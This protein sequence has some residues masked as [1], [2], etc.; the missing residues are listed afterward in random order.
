M[1]LLV[2]VLAS[3]RPSP[4]P[5]AVDRDAVYWIEDDGGLGRRL[6]SVAKTGGSIRTLGDVGGA[7]LIA[8]G[9]RLFFI[10]A[11]GVK[12]LRPGGIPHP[13]ASGEGG[14]D[15]FV[16]G[17]WIYWRNA[18]GQL[19]RAARKG[20]FAETVREN[21]AG[22]FA[23]DDEGIYPL[24]GLASAH[25]L[26]QDAIFYA[27]RGVRVYKR[28]LLPFSGTIRRRSKLGGEPV[29]LADHQNLPAG[30]MI[31]FGDFLYWVNTGDQMLV[32]LR[33][34]GGEVEPIAR[35]VRF[36]ID[37]SGIYATTPEGDIVTYALNDR[38]AAVPAIRRAG[39]RGHIRRARAASCAS[40]AGRR[41]DRE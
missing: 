41:R 12:S 7:E 16:H 20:G 22:R 23:V 27:V 25:C 6:M 37:A 31:R 4:G 13:I 32:R 15:L 18:F 30:D 14:A 38:P 17:A 40:P 34:D 19:R 8:D 21:F 9:E 26:A 3:A 2:A 33:A 24:E 5:I 39:E 36:A 28:G 35:A 11:G 10:D 29:V 1:L